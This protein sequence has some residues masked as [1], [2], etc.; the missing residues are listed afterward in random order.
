MAQ[1]MK[2]ED[3]QKQISMSKKVKQPKEE[4]DLKK[5]RNDMNLAWIKLNMAISTYN[6]YLENKLTNKRK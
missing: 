2:K 4:L 5:A 6:L 1:P 3:I